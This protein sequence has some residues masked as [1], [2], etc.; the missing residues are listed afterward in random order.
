MSD[1]TK[2]VHVCQG[3]GCTLLPYC[4]LGRHVESEPGLIVKRHLPTKTGDAC[5]H[6]APKRKVNHDDLHE[7][8]AQ[9]AGC[10]S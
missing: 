5:S 8:I 7:R 3:N 4:Y 6:F 1:T 2:I 10:L 9:L